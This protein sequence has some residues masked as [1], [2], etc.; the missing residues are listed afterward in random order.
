M[1]PTIEVTDEVLKR[2]DKLEIPYSTKAENSNLSDDFI[3]VPSTK[4]YVAKNI[5]FQGRSWDESHENG[6]QTPLEFVE[7]LKHVMEHN[8]NIYK[9]MTESR[10]LWRLEWIDACFEKR[11][12]G[13]YVLTENRE[14]A[15]KLDKNTLMENKKISL[16]SWLENPTNQGFPRED[17]KEGNLY[18]L[19][20]VHNSVAGF[21]AGGHGAGLGYGGGAGYWSSLL[22]VRAV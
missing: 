21:S 7:F 4:L 8:L 22:G 6:M 12:D 14:R 16:D 9:D 10:S 3:Y 17:V 5:S 19:P 11:K 1:P 20:P 18:F 2:L 15:E 13:M